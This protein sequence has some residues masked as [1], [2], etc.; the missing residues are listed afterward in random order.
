[1]HGFA[2]PFSHGE[3][4]LPPRCAV[5]KVLQHSVMAPVSSHAW[6]CRSIVAHAGNYRFTCSEH[7]TRVLVIPHAPLGP[8]APNTMLPF[9]LLEGLGREGVGGS[10]EADVPSPF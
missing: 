1:M 3:R 6:L 5:T 7:G 10:G 8:R 2:D 4:T 9:V